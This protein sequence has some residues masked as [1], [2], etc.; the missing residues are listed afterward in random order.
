MAKSSVTISFL[1]IPDIGESIIISNDLSGTPITEV[2]E[3]TRVTNG[4]SVIGLTQSECAIITI[5]Q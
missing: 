2:F 4:Q 1:N 5:M 3:T